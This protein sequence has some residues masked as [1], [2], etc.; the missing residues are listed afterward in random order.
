LGLALVFAVLK[1]HQLELVLGD[2]NPGLKVRISKSPAKKKR[3]NS[4]EKKRQDEI[5][6]I[7]QP[8]QLLG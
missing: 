2:N 5:D 3:L 4:K 1:L 6:F 8:S 7:E